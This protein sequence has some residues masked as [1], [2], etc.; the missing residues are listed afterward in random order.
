MQK[1]L[2]LSE[3][4]LFKGTKMIAGATEQSIYKALGLDFIEPE[5]REDRGE[6]SAAILHNL[7]KL[8]GYNDIKGDLHCHTN[9]SDGENS[10]EEMIQAAKKLGYEY[11]GVSDHTKFLRITNGLDEKRLEKRNKEIDR[12]NA[13]ENKFRILKGAEVN[14]LNDGALD[15]KDEALQKLDYVIAG[16]HTNFKMEKGEMTERIIRAIKNPNVDIISHPTGRIL[17]R[18]DEYNCDFDEILRAAKKYNVAMEINSNMYRMDLNDQNIKKAKEAGVKMIINT[19]SHSTEGLKSM[20]QGIS[21]ARRGWA[22]KEDIIN[23][24]S[25]KKLLTHFH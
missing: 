2:K 3:Y 23:T 7:P 8:I 22:K 10:I 24:N 16:V 20:E 19:D 11:L 12:L 5:L 13:R 17:K 9:Q 4:G 1:G 14:I 25:L 6:I 18:R 15:I 21:Q